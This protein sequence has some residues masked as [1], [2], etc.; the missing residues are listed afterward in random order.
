MAGLFAFFTLFHLSLPFFRPEVPFKSEAV[1]FYRFHI[2]L[3]FVYY[4][5]PPDLI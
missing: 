3:D 5:F 2:S 4:A 1:H